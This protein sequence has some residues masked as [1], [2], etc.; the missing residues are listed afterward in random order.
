M[1][2]GTNFYLI[3][4]ISH[5]PIYK[6]VRLNIGRVGET[7]LDPMG[8]GVLLRHG[9]MGVRQGEITKHVICT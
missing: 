3:I 4:E 5:P 8:V 9:K 2:T 1:F 7:I 6:P